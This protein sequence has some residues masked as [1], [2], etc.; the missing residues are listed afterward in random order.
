MIASTL[1]PS[2]QSR[3]PRAPGKKAS[4]FSRQILLDFFLVF[5][6]TAILIRPY[7]KANYE[8]K[9]ASIESTFIAD[10]RFL[11]EHWPH[12]QWQPLWYAGTR[13]DYIYPPAVRYGTAVISKVTGFWPVKAYHFYVAFFY[14]LGIAGVYLLMRVGSKSRPFAYLGALATSLMSPIFLFLPRFREDSWMLEPQRLGVLVK[15]GEGPHMSALAL[16]PIA[17]AFGWLALEKHRPWAVALAAVF[18]AGVAA[19]NFYGAA[20]L[21]VFYPILVWSLWI[22]RQEKRIVVPA[23]AIPVLAYGLTA[24]WLVPSYFQVPQE[25][26]KYVSEHGTLW[27]FWVAVVVAVAFVIVSDRFARAR[28]ER[29]WAVFIA[30]CVVFFS[31]KVFGGLYFNLRISGEPARL[32]PELDMIYIMAAALILQWLWDRPGIALRA[33]VLVVLCAAFWTTTGYIRHA[34]H[35]FP[36]SPDYQNHVEYRVTDWLWKNMPDARV[37]P[38][39][40]VRFW[41]DAWHDLPQLGGGSDQGLLNGEVASALWQTHAGAKPE[42]AILWMQCMGVDAIY[43]SDQRSQEIFKDFEYPQKFAGVLSVLYDD[44]QGNTLYRVP[45]RYPAR[46]R[47]VEARKL[48]ALK[49]PRAN[50]DVEYL[51]AYADVIEKGPDSPPTLTRDGTDAMRVRAKV[52]PGQSIVV[53][54]SWDPAWQAW[55]GGKQL[56]VRKDAM[57]FMA[58]ET[59]PGNQEVRLAFVTPLENR[60]GCVVTVVTLA[61][62]LSLMWFGMWWEAF[63][64]KL[65]LLNLLPTKLSHRRKILLDGLLLFLFTA[66]LVGPFFQAEYTDTWSS[67]ESTFVS[68]ARFLTAHWPHPQWQPLWYAGTRFDYIY[69]PAVRYGTA[70]ISKVTGFWPVKAYHFYVAFFYAL[71][72]AGVYLLMRVGSKSRPF[73]YLGAL[74]TSLMSPIFLF[75]PRFRED[76]WMLEPQRLGVLVKYGEGPHMSA[77]ALIPIALAF[78]WLALEKHRPWA[79]ALAAV[80]SAGVAANNFYGA[81]ALAVF[82]P[83]LVWSLWITRQE[84][85]IV[86]PAIAIPVLAYGLTAFWL[87]PSYF[88]VTAENLKYVSEHGTT[89]SIW[90]AVAVAVAFAVASDRFAR[91]KPERAWAVFIA[92]CVVFFSLNVLGGIYFNFRISGDPV[93]LLPELDMIYIMAA[94]LMLRWL[95]GRPGIDLRAVVLVILIAAFWTTTG[96]IRH[97]WHMFPLSP[98]Y[99]DRIE[100]RITDWLWKNMPDARAYPSG[101]VRFW[102]DAWHD[103][104]QLSGGSDQGLLNGELAPA[105]WETN[106]GAKPEPAILWMQCMGVDV[107]YVS[108]KRSQEMFKDFEHPE[109]FAGVLPVVYDDGRGNT[110]YRVPRRFPARARVVETRKLN[111]LKPPRANDDVEYLGAYADVIEKGPDSPPTLTRDG[112]DSMRVRAKVGPGQSIVVQES[113]DPA[114]QAWAGGNPLPIRKDAMGFMAVDAPPGDREIRLAFVTPLENRVGRVA[115]LATLVLLLGLVVFGRRWER[116]V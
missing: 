81:A 60:I 53:Q 87:V 44:R 11:A 4:A 104:P 76:S 112:T 45:R 50:D 7:F 9:W 39:G 3:A 55:A 79:V 105:Q 51:G 36:L 35:M 86:V 2:S 32:L 30:G 29:A 107:V 93:R 23:I 26:L 19:N 67:I 83:I 64:V 85:R 91:A 78:G 97:A 72:I 98:D 95:W 52:A 103:L 111:A 70:V 115:T 73:A 92:G 69:P 106:L 37:F 71:G 14:A 28:P 49:P 80:F 40:S 22:T 59:P 68:D 46:A 109:K 25:N 113:W 17:L 41:Y 34:W 61:L 6:Y 13:F 42:P 75:L 38:S 99:Q 1:I 94:V 66:V 16:I 31:L 88:K 57:G 12:P 47:V 8:N 48:N 90:V 63:S 82:Y 89:W 110:L 77:L 10:A 96:Y 74:A 102:Y 56:P 65:P 54:E 58:V 15:Y 27:L 116:F 24:F 18:S 84:K 100:Y 43:V 108:D 20:A 5:L 101:Y 33:V 62:L 21:A 114:W